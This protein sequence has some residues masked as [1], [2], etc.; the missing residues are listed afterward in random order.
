MLC[1]FEKW[2]SWLPRSA[3]DTA[4]IFVFSTDLFFNCM[5][6]CAE[7]LSNTVLAPPCALCLW[8]LSP[9]RGTNHIIPIK[10]RFVPN[11]DLL[12]QPSQSRSGSRAYQK[13]VDPLMPSRSV[14]ASTVPW[15]LS[16]LRFR[17]C[18]KSPTLS[19]CCFS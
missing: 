19:L 17:W 11:I 13:S 15:A 9:I 7:E 4:S 14:A 16:L 6:L 5:S 1:S 18:P 2:T 10:H 3:W 12:V 8:T